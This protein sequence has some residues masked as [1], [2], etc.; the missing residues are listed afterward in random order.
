MTPKRIAPTPRR[1][2]A[3]DIPTT[4]QI[5]NVPGSVKLAL[6]AKAASAGVSLSAYLRGELEA[7]AEI[8]SEAEVRATLEHGASRFVFHSSTKII[9]QDRVER[10]DPLHALKMRYKGSASDI[11]AMLTL[12]KRALPPGREDFDVRAWFLD[13]IK[14]PQPSLKGRTPEDLFRT[15]VGRAIVQ[16]LIG[17][18]GSGAYL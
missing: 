1:R 6:A 10:S 15:P 3:R 13:W 4:I 12:A 8:P 17:A 16:N 11:E 5:R 14:I 2:N 9:R 7:L 18:L